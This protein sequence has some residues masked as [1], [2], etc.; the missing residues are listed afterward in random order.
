[1]LHRFETPTIH[2]TQAQSLH[3]FQGLRYCLRTFGC[4]MNKH[5]SERVAGMLEALG[6]LE[7]TAVE[8]A[9]IIVFMTCCVREAADVRLMGQVASLKNLPKPGKLGDQGGDQGELDGRGGGQ[10]GGQGDGRNGDRNGDSWR[11]RRVIAVGGCIGQRD[12]GRLIEQL[13]HVDV[14]F[15]THN[16]AHLPQLIRAAFEQGSKQVEV[17]EDG[18]SEGHSAA[19]TELPTHR[20]HA[21]HAW[22]PIMTGCDNFCSYCVV[23]YVRGREKSRPFEEIVAEAARLAAEG[24]REITLLGQ[25]V[26]SYGRDLYGAPRF[27]EVLREVGASGVERLRFATSHPKDLSPETIAAFAETPAVMPQLHLPVQSGS[28]AVLKAMNRNYS[29]AHYLGLIESVRV[30]CDAAGKDVAFSTDVIVGFPGEDE[31]DFERT[32]ELVRAVG[33]SQAFTFIY[34]RR[35]GTPAATLQNEVPRAQAQERFDRLVELVQASA[36]EQ[37]QKELGAVLPVLFEGSSKRDERILAGR[38]PKGQ[39]VHVPLPEGRASAEYAGRI[40]DVAVEEARTW[41]LRGRL[42]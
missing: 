34:S 39:T 40:L 37:N 22:L 31:E 2:E 19:A 9:D 29:A 17:F 8:D 33:Y 15:G 24:V 36:W 26:N 30:A 12:G 41:Y 28:D 25:N 35:E 4:Q 20:E 14:V 11:G 16:I 21:W 7:A 38:S 27:A 1:L 5:D 10:G 3:E 32:M 6:A 23:P 42:V 13:P 18:A